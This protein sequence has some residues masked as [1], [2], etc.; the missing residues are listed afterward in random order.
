M[1]RVPLA[2]VSADETAGGDALGADPARPV[3]RRMGRGRGLPGRVPGTDRE[4]DLRGVAAALSGTV[5]GRAAADPPAPGAGVAGRR[6]PHL[7][8]S[9]APGGHAAAAGLAVAAPGAV[10]LA[11]Y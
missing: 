10:A 7:R 8:R 4:G 3:R 5:P 2:P 11:E 9:V 1:Q 6:A